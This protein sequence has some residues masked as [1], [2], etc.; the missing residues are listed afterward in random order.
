MQLRCSLVQARRLLV[1]GQLLIL[2]AT[3]PE[4]GHARSPVRGSSG[5]LDH[6]LVG[7]LGIIYPKRS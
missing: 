4:A 5:L 3:L 1:F 6:S 7:G 2:E